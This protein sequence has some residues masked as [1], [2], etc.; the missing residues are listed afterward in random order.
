VGATIA[1]LTLLGLPARSQHIPDLTQKSLEDLMS[2]E[3]TSVSK[4]EQKT[5]EAAAAVF[6]ISRED[7]RRSGALNIPDLLRMVPGVDVAQI[8][9]SYWAI[10]V[11]GFNGQY[12]DKLLVLIDGRTVYNPIFAGVFWDA[13]NVILDNIERIE[14]IR[15]PGAAVWGSNAVNGVI[16]IITRSAANTQGGYAS[17]SAGNASTGPGTIGYGSKIRGLGTYRIYANGFQYNSQPTLA[18]LNGQDDWRLARTGFRIDSTL[19]AKDSLTTEVEVYRGNAGE[20]TTTPV[21]L[22][23]PVTATLA[24]RDVYSGWNALSRWNRIESPRSN[25]S[26]QVYFD[27][28]TRGDTTYYIGLNT[29]DIDFQHHVLWGARQDIVWGL[30][31]RV[32]SDDTAPTLR[33]VFT[34]NDRVTQLFSSFVQ[35]EVALRRD[36]LHL[37]LGARVEHNSYT[38][39]DVEPSARLVWTPD[40]KNMVWG[41]VSGADRTPARTDTDVRV[42]YTA[43]PGPG[44]MPILVSVFGNPNFRNERLTAFEAGYRNTW[45]SSFS[46]DSTIF[47]NRYRDLVS[48]EPGATSIETNPAPTHLLVPESFGNGLHGE[49]H[50]IELFANWKVASS[51][52]LSPGYS[53]F[54]MHL[55]PFAGS[56]DF[57]DAAGTEG[58][59]PDH[60]AQLR[61]SVSLPWNLQWNASAYFVNRLPAVSIPSYTRVDTG[62]IWRGGEHVSLSVAGQNL[63]KNLHPEYS[64]PD[65]TVQPGLMRRAAY[66][67]VTWS[68]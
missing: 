60:K 4:K 31:Y 38:G 62:L 33:I 22:L 10:S 67:K 48:V 44:G 53:F 8:D 29:F 5:S 47:Y 16:N 37:S 45:T 27:R 15:G 36:R 28:T 41:A 24:L 21:S 35:D 1:L 50:G 11:R 61:S 57:T 55:H 65:S 13:Q 9:A 25:T 64:G 58:G 66:A 68:F 63:L 46:L 39:I 34:P 6:V 12:S 54:S 17:G 32:S 40:S 49:T 7:I 42:N 19:S 3:V 18:G 2:I 59:S 52:T 20:L 30:G 51:W 26:L 14:V 43:L 56:Q 23:P